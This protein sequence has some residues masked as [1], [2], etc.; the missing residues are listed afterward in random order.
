M[1]VHTDNLFILLQLHKN[2]VIIIIVLTT[3]IIN[4]I[5]AIY[6]KYYRLV[7]SHVKL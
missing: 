7:E 1:V 2:Y 4:V 6:T 3:V 5:I